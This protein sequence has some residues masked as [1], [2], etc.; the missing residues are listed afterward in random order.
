MTPAEKLY[1]HYK[2]KGGFFD[3]GKPYVLHI[4]DPARQI[5][6]AVF[7]LTIIDA[8]R[9]SFLIETRLASQDPLVLARMSYAETTIWERMISPR[10]LAYLCTH[11][12]NEHT[13]EDLDAYISS[14]MEG[15]SGL[16]KI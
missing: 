13:Y 3:K 11:F 5:A 7:K 10:K 15:L 16:V 8:L 14:H 6:N 2:R 1:D 4:L 9:A 12:K